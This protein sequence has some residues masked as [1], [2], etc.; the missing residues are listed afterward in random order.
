M[1]EKEIE[2]DISFSDV[3]QAEER[4]KG[5]V[6][7]GGEMA[8][9][10]RQSTE[11]PTKVALQRTSGQPTDDQVLW[12]AI[13]NR[14]QAI[15]FNRYRTFI[16]RVLCHGDD[17]DRDQ[18]SYGSPSI[19]KNRKNLQGRFTIHG[20]DAYNLLKQATEAFLIFE[21]GVV[22]KDDIDLFDELAESRRLGQSVNLEELETRLSEYLGGG[23]LPY[24]DRI[25]KQIV[26]LNESRQEEAMPYCE[27]ILQYRLTCPS[28]LELIWSY[29]Q[30]QGML[31][32]T[33]NALTLRFQN[34]RSSERDPLI[35]LELDPLRPLN[36]LLWGFVQDEFNRLSVQRRAYEY[37]H[38]YG[39]TLQGKAIRDFRPVDS[40]SKF[41]EAFHNL[42]YRAAMFYRDD[43]DTTIV[44]DAFALLNALR[45][46]HLILAEGAHNQFGDLPWTARREMLIIQWLL[47]RPEMREFLRGRHMVP[48]QEPWMG[49]VDDMRRL[50]GW[51]DVT[52]THFHE[53]AKYGE[54]IL[55]SI[56]YGDWID[57]NDQEHARNW[58]RYWRP[59][60]QRY[61]HAYMA[62]TGVDLST[63]VTDNRQT[64]ERY[65]QP[66]LH[67]QRKLAAQHK[68]NTLL[69]DITT[70]SVTSSEVLDYAELPYRSGRR[71]LRHDM[72]E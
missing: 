52:I 33:I 58:A 41:L 13:R 18:T 4:L 36:N 66:S 12:T 6:K 9:M 11:R 47:A 16:D 55:L 29:W 37:D 43:D 23:K 59:E 15:G 49:A 54:Q 53:L 46:V 45:E 17:E 20:V 60:I 35:N 25:V 51:G 24:L 19:G 22:I 26:G 57:I 1:D 27:S 2:G 8:D 10:L 64:T 34:R 61:I 42:L 14:T 44:A 65:L 69:S 48:Y 5:T 56:R 67:L 3:D 38:H 32:Q 68:Q 39:L 30:E 40:R 70:T 28:L 50:Q 72:E 7:I 21:C 31:V 71:L 62:T 63:E